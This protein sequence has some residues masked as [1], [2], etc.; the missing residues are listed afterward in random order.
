MVQVMGQGQPSGQTSNSGETIE[1][2]IEAQD[3]P[4]ALSLHDGDVD[5]V[6]CR[7]PLPAQHDLFWPFRPPLDLPGMFHR[8][9]PAMNRTPAE[10]HLAALWQRE[11]CAREK[12][13]AFLALFG[14]PWL[15]MGT[16][17]LLNAFKRNPK[18]MNLRKR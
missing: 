14:L 12:H 11:L 9:L 5:R 2:S 1:S 10:S 7:Q 3:S 13:E 16:K 17:I 8:Q 6:S 15:A 4:D 18:R